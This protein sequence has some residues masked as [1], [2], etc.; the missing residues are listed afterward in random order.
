MVDE[1]RR[2]GGLGEAIIAGLVERGFESQG[3]KLLTAHDTY[4]P[5]GPAM[6]RVMPSDEDVLASAHALLGLPSA[7]R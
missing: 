1:C 2:S 6:Y 3:L 5:L 7:R 4:V